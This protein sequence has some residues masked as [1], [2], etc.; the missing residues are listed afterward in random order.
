MSLIIW[1]VI[2]SAVESA[3]FRTDCWLT[4]VGLP[5]KFVA[6]TIFVSSISLQ[7]TRNLINEL[8]YWAIVPLTSLSSCENAAPT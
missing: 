3:R 7:V 8:N 4:L 5:K 6:T 1:L 2:L